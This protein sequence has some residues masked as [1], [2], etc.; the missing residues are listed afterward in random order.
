MKFRA[1]I[2]CRNA[3]QWV[4][5]CLRSVL[6]QQGGHDILIDFT[7]DASTDGTTERAE[8]AFFMEERAKNEIQFTSSHDVLSRD[9]KLTV[10]S[11]RFGA[12]ENIWH[13]IQRSQ[14]DEV[15]ILIG[16]DDWLSSSEALSR[17]AR[18]YES[19]DVWLT[20]GQQWPFGGQSVRARVMDRP[21]AR[22]HDFVWCNPLTWR[23][24]LGKK[25]RKQDLCFADGTFFPSSGDVALTIPM[26]EMAGLERIRCIED[27]IYF[28]NLH[29]GNDGTVDKRL[30]DFCGWYARSKPRY[31]RLERLED[32][33]ELDTEETSPLEY[34]ILFMPHSPDVA[35]TGLSYVDK[36]L[37]VGLMERPRQV[38]L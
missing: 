20:Y 31:H 22:N 34:G 33:P 11:R 15:C 14:D 26:V 6:E 1:I 4:E 17:I 13:A 5:K 12:L 10:N 23:A 8:A 19:G 36:T 18:E 38:K 3:E 2:T 29:D 27:V 7:D 32:A 35:K 25:I 24:P 30:Q 37:K 21:D 16:G 9:R 28:Y